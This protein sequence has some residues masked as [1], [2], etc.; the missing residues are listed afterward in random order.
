MIS[1]FNRTFHLQRFINRSLYGLHFFGFIM[2]SLI[3]RYFSVGFDL[4]LNCKGSFGNEAIGFGFKH[5]ANIG[6]RS[7]IFAEAVDR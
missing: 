6:E 2:E 4:F 1:T 5:S 7:S 3:D